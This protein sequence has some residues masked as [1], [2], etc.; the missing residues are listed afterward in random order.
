MEIKHVIDMPEWMDD[1]NWSKNNEAGILPANISASSKKKVFWKCHV[2]GGEWETAPQYRKRNG[3]PYCANFKALPGYNDLRTL[4]PDI[5]AEWD[6]QKNGSLFP[7]NVTKGSGKKVWWIC[8]KGHSYDMYVF[9]RVKGGNCP[10][11]NNRRVLCGYNDLQ[12]LRPEI[13]QTWH[14]VLNEC[15]TPEDVIPGTKKQVWWQCDK[16]HEWK[17]SVEQRCRSKGCPICQNRRIIRKVND[18]FTL[19]PELQEEWDFERNTK[20]PK[21]YTG[22]SSAVVW[23]KC[24]KGHHWKAAISDR[25]RGYNCP[26]CSE[27]RRVSFPEKAILYYVK[28][29]FPDVEANYRSKWLGQQELDIYIP[30]Q[31]IAIEYDGEYGHSKPVCQKRDE[32]KNRLCQENRILLIRIREP[33]CPLLENSSVNYIMNSSKDLKEAIQFVLAKLSELTE[34]NTLLVQSDID[35]SRDS[36]EIYSL[37]QYSEKENSLQNKAPDIVA[38]WHPIRNKTLTPEFVSVASSKRVWW[39]GTCGH[40]WQSP[41]AYE[42]LSGKCP[43]CTGKRILKGFNDLASQKPT[44]ASQWNNQKNINLKP[45]EVT[46]G[47]GKRVWWICEKGHEWQATIVSRTRDKKSG[48]PICGNRQVLSGYNDIASNTELL[49]NWDYEKNASLPENVCIGTNKKF[50]WKCSICGHQWKDEVSA[51]YRGKGCPCCNKKKR[52]KAVQKTY[53]QKAG[54]S[55][56]DFFPQ[57]LSEWDWDVNGDLS[58][59]EIVAGYGKPIWWKCKKCGNK[60]QATGIMRTRANHPT[61]CPVCGKL[62]QAAARQKTILKNGVKPLSQTHP[63]LALELQKK[64]EVRGTNV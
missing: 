52:S 9:E 60:W 3:C 56:A 4:F 20:Q 23:W 39:K 41:V 53:I 34:K 55:L 24:K 37:I 11:C 14:P 38:L 16:G 45:D 33:L 28:K 7:E 31:I 2:C 58:P 12:T 17:A 50:Y 26:E 8:P 46:V 48:C 36:A 10:F 57:L 32:K 5:A 19:Y 13:A 29:I 59:Y 35:I 43:Y 22:G 51:Q 1:W 64:K 40:E 42:V 15:L 25:S 30:E 18:L 27:E 47:S 54:G 6:A 63:E 62:K 61:G 44:I 49:K 21:E